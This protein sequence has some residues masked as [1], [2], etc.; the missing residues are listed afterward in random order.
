MRDSLPAR[1]RKMNER[2]IINLD[3]TDGPGTHWVAYIKKGDIVIYFDSFGNLRP[4]EEI[5][6]Y[7]KSAGNDVVVKYNHESYQTYDSSNCG[8]LCLNFLR[9]C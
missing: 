6:K 8:A 1:I 3:G 2:G 7:F 5:V 4:S 9:S